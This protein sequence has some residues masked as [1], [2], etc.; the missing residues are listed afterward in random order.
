MNTKMRTRFFARSFLTEVQVPGNSKRTSIVK[1]LMGLSLF[2]VFILTAVGLYS[3]YAV[4]LLAENTNELITER[5][6][7]SASMSLVDMNHDAIRGAVFHGIIAAKTADAKKLEEAEKELTEYTENISKYYLETKTYIKDKSLLKIIDAANEDLVDYV[8]QAKI[9]FAH[10]KNLKPDLAM[11]GFDQFQNSFE[12]LE[13]SLGKMSDEIH[14]SAKES[15]DKAL[16]ASANGKL[17]IGIGVLLGLLVTISTSA[18][19]VTRMKKLMTGI[20][21]ELDLESKKVESSSS[22][23][24][25]SSYHLESILKNQ[26]EAT[27][28]S[29]AALTQVDSMIG[30]TNDISES[31]VGMLSQARVAAQDGRDAATKMKESMG[32]ISESS[33]N[34]VQQVRHNSEKMQNVLSVIS[35]IGE[36]T[37]IINEIVFQTKLLSFN[38]SV[39][40]ARAGEHGKGFSVVAEEIGNLARVSGSAAKD[41]SEM[42]ETG[43]QRV[44]SI[45]DDTKAQL[46][47]SADQST[48][49]VSKG[50]S[51]VDRCYSAIELILEDFLQFDKLANQVR[52]ATGEQSHGVKEARHAAEII[53]EGSRS[54]STSSTQ[55]R[56]L[57]QDMKLQAQSLVDIVD[58]LKITM[59]DAS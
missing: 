45:V 20:L 9:I 11:A 34:L 32:Q 4:N 52:V 41:I 51:D 29:S 58:K 36:K 57:A 44:N 8:N 40:A 3:F 23:L 43:I 56:G 13:K 55:S 35:E 38:A 14:R 19:L 50:L 17:S 37:K 30:R 5:V 26:S 12:K 18:L 49:S 33:V 2:F 15:T 10:C 6:P 48:K 1:Q 28:E 39:E 54:I 59:L 47:T 25:E 42:L 27:Q 16:A 24:M 53:D 22:T 31:L 21:Y 46:E 7:S